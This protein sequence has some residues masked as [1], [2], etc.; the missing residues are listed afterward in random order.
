MHKKERENLAKK[1]KAD[2]DEEEALGE[3]AAEAADPRGKNKKARTCVVDE[4]ADA[5]GG[6][7]IRPHESRP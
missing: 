5:L 2:E 1:R 3:D 7:G 4:L 6:T